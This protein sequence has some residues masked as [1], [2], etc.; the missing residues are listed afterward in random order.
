MRE[1]RNAMQRV[2]TLVRRPMVVAADLDFLDSAET[3]QA[4]DWLAGPLP[5]AVGR[6]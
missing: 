5:E 1:L 4:C 3:Q 2:A 6:V